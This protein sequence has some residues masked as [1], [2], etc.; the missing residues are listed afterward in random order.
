MPQSSTHWFSESAHQRIWDLRRGNEWQ[1]TVG[2]L[3]W[4]PFLQ[5]SFLLA[6]L[7]ASMIMLH[8]ALSLNKHEEKEYWM[9]PVVAFK[10]QLKKKKTIEEKKS[11]VSSFHSILSNLSLICVF[12]HHETEKKTKTSASPHKVR[13]LLLSGEDQRGMRGLAGSVHTSSYWRIF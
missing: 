11:T 1:I 8:S 4:R 2:C 13:L 7:V 9:P 12:L 6:V 5:D 3:Y 10:A